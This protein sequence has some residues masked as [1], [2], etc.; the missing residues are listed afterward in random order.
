MQMDERI[1]I[2]CVDP[3]CTQRWQ[4]VLQVKLVLA[5]RSAADAQENGCIALLTMLQAS[6]GRSEAWRRLITWTRLA[7]MLSQE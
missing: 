3:R 5:R 1:V 7:G 6:T 4:A 2:E